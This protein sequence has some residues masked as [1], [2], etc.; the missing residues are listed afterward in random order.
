MP[1]P[2]GG[3]LCRR[4]RRYHGH[5]V[6]RR[7]VLQR[8]GEHRAPTCAGATV[9]PSASAVLRAVRASAMFT[10]DR[11]SLQRVLGGHV[12]NG[13]LGRP[14]P[15][16]SVATTPVTGSAVCACVA[17]TYSPV[18]SAAS[19]APTFSGQP[20]QTPPPRATR[21]PCP[22][23]RPAAG[24]ADQTQN[25]PARGA[26]HHPVNASASVTFYGVRHDARAPRAR[27]TGCRSSSPTRASGTRISRTAD[28]RRWGAE[29]A[30]D[31]GCHLGRAA[32]TAA[33]LDVGMAPSRRSQRGPAAA[34]HQEPG[35][36][37]MRAMCPY[38]GNAARR[39]QQHVSLE[40]RPG[41]RRGVWQTAASLPGAS[42]GESTSCSAAATPGAA[43]ATTFDSWRNWAATSSSSRSRPD[44]GGATQ[45]R[46]DLSGFHSS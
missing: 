7:H 41:H 42:S 4:D 14:V 38:V 13:V 24:A 6:F 12:V 15:T 10:L 30:H 11:Q 1:T 22:A 44:R 21:R 33:V 34:R 17:G 37:P 25:A 32:S 20:A 27:T 35:P 23:A 28:D 43:G 31:L 39:V 45:I 5:G 26:H 16:S 2:P 18:A 8:D 46:R 9:A 40:R 36:V 19:N 3:L 29:A